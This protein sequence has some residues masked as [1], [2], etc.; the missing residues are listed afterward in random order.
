VLVAD[1]CAI[2]GCAGVAAFAAGAGNGRGRASRRDGQRS[3]S[4]PSVRSDAKASRRDLRLA[5]GVAAGAEED[6]ARRFAIGAPGAAV[7]ETARGEG[8]SSSSA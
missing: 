1:D 3:S 5:R 8:R 2:L 7:S 6:E 4:G